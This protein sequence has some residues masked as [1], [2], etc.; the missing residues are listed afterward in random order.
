MQPC[1]EIK[2]SMELINTLMGGIIRFCNDLVGNRYF[3]ALLIFAIIVEILLLP[4]G[5][6]QQRNS[7]KQAMLRPKEMAIR[8]KYAGRE[9][10][11]TKQKISQEI[12]EMYSK[13]GYS[14]MAGCLQIFIQFPII[15]ALYNIVMNPLRYICGFSEN[16]IN[17]VM[18]IVKGRKCRLC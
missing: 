5:I 16:A 8:K 13:E 15:I 18:N 12:Q 10:N 2:V 6:M 7:R 14:P 1:C 9:D 17:A 11:A 4:F 3:F